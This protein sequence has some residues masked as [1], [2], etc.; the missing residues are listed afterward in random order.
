MSDQL[1]TVIPG[2]SAAQFAARLADNF[3]RGWASDDAKYGPNGNVYALLLSLGQQLRAVQGELQYTLAAQRVLTETFP[4]LDFASVDFLG[5][6]FPRPAGMTDLAFGKAIIAALFQPAATRPALQNALTALTG[7]VP[8]MLE[9]WSV[10]DTGSWRNKSFWNVDTVAN[11][12]R[13]GNGGLRYQGYIETPPPAIPAIG[14][15]NPIRCWGN[16]AYWN[17]PG[18]FFGIIQPVDINA[19]DDEVIRL[20][21]EGTIVWM[22]IVNPS[23]GVGATAPNTVTNLVAV[24]AGTNSVLLSWVSPTAGTPP[25]ASSVLYRQTGAAIW[26]SGPT[27]TANTAT[28]QNLAPGVQYDFQIV[29]RNSAGAAASTIVSASTNRVPPTPAQNL[30]AT[31]VQA[32]AVTLAWQQPIIGTPPFTYSVNYRI[33]GTPIWQ[34]LTVGQGA[35]TVTVISLLPNTSYDFEVLA[36]NL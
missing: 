12:A 5:D 30:I 22:K 32:T 7:T 27:V 33:T 34:T 17:V 14:P 20:K 19:I 9:P 13:W 4:E 35:L 11:P 25:F 8:R 23:A 3:P 21:A 31:Q 15:N 28:V 16:S 1:P 29:V 2:L 6:T 24:A 26:I 18:Y 10:N 36:T